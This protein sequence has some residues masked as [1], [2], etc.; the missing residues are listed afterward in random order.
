MSTGVGWSSA[1]LQGPMP[2]PAACHY[3]TAADGYAL[4]DPGCTP[5]AVDTAVSPGNLRSTICRSGYTASV[6]PPESMT[7]PAK[8]RSMHAYAAPGRTSQYEYDHLVPLELGGSSDVRN[9]WPEPNAGSP[10]QSDT[11]DAF[12]ANG[13]DGV[14]GR[15]RTAVCSGQVALA[16]AQAAMAHDW[17]TAESVLGVGR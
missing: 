2:D 5:G 15:L 4:P 1:G 11:G 9:L 16:A 17:T 13:K 10:S 14:E 12:G 3:R 7:E 8:I 6:R